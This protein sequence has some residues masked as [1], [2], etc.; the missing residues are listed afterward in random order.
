[1]VR[2]FAKRR[3]VLRRRSSGRLRLGIKIGCDAGRIAN[4]LLTSHLIEP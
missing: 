1:M 4:D 2:H 3:S